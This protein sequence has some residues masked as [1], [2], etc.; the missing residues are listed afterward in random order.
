MCLGKG[1]GLVM[2]QKKNTKILIILIILVLLIILVAGGV[3]AYLVTDLFRSDKDIFFKYASKLAD[4][5][6]GLI[7]ENL[8]QYIEK[9]KTNAY[10]NE[11]EFKPN[12][13]A[14]SGQSEFDN[15][16]KFNASF[17]GKVDKTN[18]KSE[19]N[20][21]LN[22]SD[23]VKFPVNYRK[24]DNETGLQTDYVGNKYIVLDTENTSNLANSSETQEIETDINSLEKI[25]QLNLSE[26]EKDQII[27]TYMQV[28]TENL[29]T[30]K[31][32]KITDSNKKGYKLQLTGDDIKNIETKLLET[33]K[34]DQTTLDKLNEYLKE[35]KNSAKITSNTID[36]AIKN[37]SNQDL[38]NE[39]LE[40]TLFVSKGKVDNIT[41]E[42]N[43]IKLEIAKTENNNIAQYNINFEVLQNN[44][45]EAISKILVIA[46]Y[47]GLKEKQ[48]VSESYEIEL[49][50]EEI[51][52][53]YKIDNNVSFGEGIE[54][55]DFS[56]S[57]SMKLADYDEEKVATFMQA[58]FARIEQTNKKQM[59]ELGVE[60]NLITKMFPSLAETFP[61]SQDGQGD[62]ETINN[63]NQKFEMYASTN[64][65]GTTVKGLITTISTNNGINSSSDE[66]DG[67]DDEQD[68][69]KS[70]YEIK[71]INYNGEEYDV[72]QQNI[73]FIKS[74]V[75]VDKYYRVE[76]EKDQ[77][78][79]VIYRAVINEK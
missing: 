53:D 4:K 63:F 57:N 16:N 64:L 68:T 2:K 48:K 38:E 76:F 61:M 46:K 1:M 69:T 8:S 9:K 79:G 37:I 21:S 22:Y 10:T 26:T 32:S 30:D 34:N 55:E 54:I 11:A 36:R 60:E 47:E 43:E 7:D 74:D 50:N 49:A 77:D 44:N 5:K 40:I 24:I 25:T 35:Q 58:V 75:A 66:D 18:S 70:K 17:T 65:Q 52:Y 62:E 14:K 31:F 71:E 33:L 23:S 78:T 39:K 42:T 13:T 72:N 67:S 28:L 51:T 27:N 6:Q 19:Q 41:I 12:V 3:Y 73:T 20:V 45:Q 15:V 29:T 59:E 56:N